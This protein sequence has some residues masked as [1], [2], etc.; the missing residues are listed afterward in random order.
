M[1]T[2]VAQNSLATIRTQRRVGARIG[3]VSA[4]RL[5]PVAFVLVLAAACGGIVVV[6]SD[7]P[8]PSGGSGG[9][10][11]ATT[12]TQ[13][14]TGGSTGGELC[15]ETAPNC[16]QCFGCSSKGPCAAEYSAAMDE[17]AQQFVQCFIDPT[18]MQTGWEECVLACGDVHPGGFEKFKAYTLCVECVQ[19]PQCQDEWAMFCP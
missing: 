19:C 16:T 11:Q 5:A 7:S 9:G 12:S 18:C 10:Q 17:D 2:R 6:D 15:H 3:P 13:G 4:A 1:E 8:A 14:S